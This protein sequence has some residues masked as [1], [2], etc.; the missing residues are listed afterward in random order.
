M[1]YFTELW[2]H[3]RPHIATVILRKK[4]E[5]GGIMLPNIKLYYKAIVV[6]R[7]WYWHKNTHRSMEQNKKPRNKS[8]P[9]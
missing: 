8:I 5:L 9:F 2:D 3:K 1:M 4:Y 6:K 7:A